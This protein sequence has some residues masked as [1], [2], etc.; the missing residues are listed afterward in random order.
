MRLYLLIEH[1]LEME[2]GDGYEDIVIEEITMRKLL[3]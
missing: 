3:T 1:N 2:E